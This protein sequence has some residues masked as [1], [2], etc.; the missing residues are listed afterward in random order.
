MQQQDVTFE[1]SFTELFYISELC[2]SSSSLYIL[3]SYCHLLFFYSYTSSLI[4]SKCLFFCLASCSPLSQRTFS[5]WA[6]RRP[7]EDR[8][9]P[10]DGEQPYL[11]MFWR[12][13]KKKI[14]SIFSPMGRKSGIPAAKSKETLCESILHCHVVVF[15]CSGRLSQSRVLRVAVGDGAGRADHP[16]G[17][18]R[19][20]EHPLRVS[21]ASCS[22]QSIPIITQPLRA[23][24]YYRKQ[25]QSSASWIFLKPWISIILKACISYWLCSELQDKG[26]VE[27]P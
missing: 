10:A 15:V 20:Q 17:S 27:Q 11:E 8:G 9:H 5:G 18:H 4:Y 19:L 3:S 14:T 7:A 12:T 24:C 2:L 16:A 1:S 13:R 21:P 23:S 26:T 6:G 22:W 25:G